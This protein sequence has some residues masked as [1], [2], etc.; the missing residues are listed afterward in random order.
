MTTN[1][2]LPK[3]T[4]IGGFNAGQIANL[5]TRKLANLICENS[6]MARVHEFALDLGS[7]EVDCKSLTKGKLDFDLFVERP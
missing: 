3:G 6:E 7:K 2:E 4:V 1:P 5:R